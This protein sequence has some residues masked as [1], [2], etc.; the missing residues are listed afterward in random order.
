MTKSIHVVPNEGKWSV[1][2]KG[3]TTS[4]H[5]KQET[6]INTALP[7]AKRQGTELVIHGR[8]GRIRS[9]DS[10]GRDPMPPRDR[11]N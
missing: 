3:R 4:E 11:E 5:Y 9:K 8:D 10:Y 2:Q 1:K 6:A 7:I